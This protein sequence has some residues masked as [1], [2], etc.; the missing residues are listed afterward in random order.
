MTWR[1]ILPLVV[2]VLSALAHAEELPVRS[3][4]PD[5]SLDGLRQ[6]RDR[7]LFATNRRPPA[8]A[9]VVAVAKTSEAAALAAQAE[10]DD[11]KMSLLGI[12]QQSPTP[13]IILRDERKSAFL[14][15]RSGERVGRWE[16]IA[17]DA[18]TA[19]LVGQRR[20]VT[21]EMFKK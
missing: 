16:I 3:L 1:L 9:S 19:R 21:L 8:P 4:F 12:I 14:T 15:V 17:V 11:P 13:I 5:L 20:Q 2:V 10:L 18:W 7:P 6:T